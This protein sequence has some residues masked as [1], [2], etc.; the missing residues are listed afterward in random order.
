MKMK[1]SKVKDKESWEIPGKL[2]VIREVSRSEDT[3]SFLQQSM[4][5]GLEYLI[6]SI[7]LSGSFP[8]LRQFALVKEM[9]LKL[10]A[11]AMLTKRSLLCRTQFSLDAPNFMTGYCMLYSRPSV[12]Y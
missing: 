3:W 12:S 6:T 8:V 10:S 11:Q 4:G 7:W 5:S 2:T 9:P 1:Y